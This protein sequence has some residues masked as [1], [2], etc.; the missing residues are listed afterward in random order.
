M[1]ASST[2]QRSRATFSIKPHFSANALMTVNVRAAIGCGKT[3]IHIVVMKDVE[4][5]EAT[6]ARNTTWPP[7]FD[8]II[9]G[10]FSPRKVCV[11][12][13]HYDLS[14]R[15]FTDSVLVHAEK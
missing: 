10:D 1:T 8:V 12:Q 5:P 3:I 6:I 2:W 15:H 14:I 7:G 13:F 9:G 4:A 11:Q